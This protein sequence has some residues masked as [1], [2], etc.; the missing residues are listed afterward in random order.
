MHCISVFLII[1][2]FAGCAHAPYNR[3]Y[4][5]KSLNERTGHDLKAVSKLEDFKLPPEISRADG[6]TAEE[7][8]AIALW[9]NAQFQ[10]DLT[11]LGFARA[12]LIEAGLL[13]N[14]MLSL[15]FPV[16]PK[17]LEAT[18]GLPIDFLWQRPQRVAAA[19]LEAQRVAENL[20][21]HGLDL[22]R[23]VQIAYA[24][25]VLAQTQKQIAAENARLRQEIAAIAAARLRAG[26]LSELEESASRLEALRA[27]EACLGFAQDAEISRARFNMLLGIDVQ[28]TSFVLIPALEMELPRRSLPELF[29]A[30]FASRP[31]LRAA[32]LAIEAA[33]KRLGWERAKI[34][35]FNGVLDANAAGKEGFEIGPGAQIEIP[36]FNW[37]NG[38]VVRAKAQ[39][40]QAAR[41]Y[42]VVR[43]RLAL[44]VQEA[45]TNYLAAQQALALCRSEWVPTA[46]A[47]ASQAQKAYAAGEV[48]YL[49]V[50]EINRQLLDAR[51]RE[52]EAAASFHRATARLQHGIGFYQMEREN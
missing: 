16:G 2:I 6:L 43:H 27:Q 36:L 48:S 18:L 24:D 20:V 47:A 40:E 21:Q 34:L 14:P 50:L 28:D 52:A 9:N 4:V 1:L 15:L 17:Q 3:A 29:N 44:E 42:L 30:A 23:D 35:A 32:E 41:Q 22:A 8:V 39:M 46:T 37:N 38:K 11:E 5:A 13:R 51:R 49:F 45:Y 19:K 31:D 26:D 33:G 12:D 25:L 10:A 7:G